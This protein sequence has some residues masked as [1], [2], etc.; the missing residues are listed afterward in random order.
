MTAQQTADAE[1]RAIED[2]WRKVDGE[3]QKKR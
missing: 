2:G 1:E 3:W